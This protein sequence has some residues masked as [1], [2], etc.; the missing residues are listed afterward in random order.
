MQAVAKSKDPARKK[1]S[2]L[3]DGGGPEINVDVA[4]GDIDFEILSLP[5][6]RG[7]F[8]NYSGGS[9]LGGKQ[10]SK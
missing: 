1:A 10:P 9:S 8:S 7:A 4:E 2:R 6:S 3:G 5:R